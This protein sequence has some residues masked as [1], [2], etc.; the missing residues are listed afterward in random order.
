M[1]LFESARLRVSRAQTRAREMSETWNA[2]LAPH[3][4]EFLLLRT[5]PTEYLLRIEQNQ[6]TPLDLPALFGEWLY[7]LR[8]ALDHVVWAAAAYS[9]GTVPPAGEDGLQ[10]PIYDTE[11]SWKRNLWRLRP[12]ADH[13]VAMLK[14]MQPYNSDPDANYLG[15]INRLARIDRHRRLPVWTARIAEAEPVFQIPSGVAPLLEW[16]QRTFVRQ[17]CDLAR[18]TFPDAASADGIS[19]NPRVGIDPE[20]AEWGASDFWKRI[21]FSERLKLMAIFVKAEVDVYEYD[22]TGS[23]K[24]RGTVTD[25]FAQE[26][27]LRRQTGAFP[28]LQYPEPEQPSWT[29][30]SPPEASTVDRLLGLD[31]PA[32]GSG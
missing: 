32:H 1:D 12:L 23:P 29:P 20:I 22:C 14:M 2:Y 18:A 11:E 15:W 7:N 27:D 8:S 19:F 5:S 24:A 28:P 10:Y 30:S 3:P 21:R 17:R 31:F 4:F 16:G 13:Q 25:R 6:P 26:A 9:S